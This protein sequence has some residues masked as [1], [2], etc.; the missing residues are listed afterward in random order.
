MR[1]VTGQL[2]GASAFSNHDDVSVV[3]ENES[4]APILSGDAQDSNSNSSASAAT[5]PD[6]AEDENETQTTR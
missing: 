2:D 4:S 3:F 1:L 6:R 5:H